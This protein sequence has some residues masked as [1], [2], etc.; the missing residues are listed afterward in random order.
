MKQLCLS[1]MTLSLLSA[2]TWAQGPVIKQS[3]YQLDAPPFNS[4][5]TPIPFRMIGVV[6]ANTE[7]WLDP[8]EAYNDTTPFNLGGQAEV[9]IQAVDLDGTPYDPYTGP[10]QS[11]AGDPLAGDF[12]GTFLWMGQNY[13]NLPFVSDSQASYIDQGMAG[14]GEFRPVWYDELDRL[15]VWRPGTA[16]DES[17]LVR[18]GDLIE[19]RAGINGLEFRGKHNVNERHDLDPANDYEIVI[20]EKGYGLPEAEELELSDLKDAN[21]VDIYDPTRQTGGEQY[22][23]ARVELQG[24]VFD[25]LAPGD[26]LSSDTNLTVT[27]ATGRTF[28]VYLGLNSSFDS[29]VAPGGN[30]SITGVLDQLSTGA[31]RDDGYYLIVTNAADIL[32]GDA[33][34][35]GDVDLADL[36]LWQRQNGT[37]ATPAGSGAD[38]DGSGFVDGDDLAVW[39][40]A[41]DG[42]AIP[43]VQAVPEPSVL[44]LFAAAVLPAF[45]QRR[46]RS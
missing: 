6:I 45:A 30:L 9:F 26:P 14:G 3:D 10:G 25:G 22:Q 43:A 44:A 4:Y 16:L 27:D 37:I 5:S 32:S 31:A 39:Q 20:L 8:T 42:G 2:H 15:G 23:A 13:G 24:V 1:L 28:P 38:L 36:M 21:D 12:G 17:E 29:A 33:D 41:F 35:D 11:G 46:G 18:A 34:L 19:V 7:D 40:D